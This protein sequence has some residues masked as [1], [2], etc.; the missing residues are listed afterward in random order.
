MLDEATE[1]IGAARSQRLEGSTATCLIAT[2]GCI[3]YRRGNFTLGEA[4]YREAIE[5]AKVQSDAVTGQRA[6]VHWL[7]EEG[8]AGHRLN[9]DEAARIGKFF[10]EDKSVPGATR[11]LF[12][13][14]VAPYI[15]EAVEFDRL[16][17][18][19]QRVFEELVNSSKV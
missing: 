18:D 8:R 19:A 7:H 11:E 6:F 15:Q 2:E 5:A 14:H 12:R 16:I 1:D 13:L 3:E 4:K 9:G 17:Q 10:E